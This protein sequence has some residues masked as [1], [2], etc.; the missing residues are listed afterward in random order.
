[1]ASWSS[2]NAFFEWMT[3]TPNNNEACVLHA[4]C[5]SHF[6][7]HGHCSGRLPHGQRLGRI[8]DGLAAQK[9]ALAACYFVA[10][11]TRGLRTPYQDSTTLQ[12]C[13]RPLLSRSQPRDG[14]A[15]MRCEPH[16]KQLL[17]TLG[18]RRQPNATI[19]PTALSARGGRMRA[20][21]KWKRPRPDTP[22]RGERAFARQNVGRVEHSRTRA[23]D[24]AVGRMFLTFDGT[25]GTPTKKTRKPS[26]PPA[27]IRRAPDL[28][29]RRDDTL[30]AAAASTV[31]A[32][33][34]SL[35]ERPKREGRV[36]R[37]TAA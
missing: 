15:C 26:V 13:T 28:H 34:G 12:L 19:G 37:A 16:R 22:D 20:G 14:M 9:R 24:W 17:V 29:R 35:A 21:E 25:D 33:R 3:T 5:E 10:A 36:E 6:A 31:S 1:M 23:C 27:P 4:P 8:L 11:R 2:V 7:K 18:V 32:V 30:L